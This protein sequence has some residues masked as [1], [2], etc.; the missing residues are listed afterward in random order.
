MLGSQGIEAQ[1]KG[2]D[3]L[4]VAGSCTSEAHIFFACPLELN[5]KK[6]LWLLQNMPMA[7]MSATRLHQLYMDVEQEIS[8]CFCTP[9]PGFS[10]LSLKRRL[11]DSEPNI[12]LEVRSECPAGNLKT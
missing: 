9:Y 8:S 6:R 3:L 12:S 5:L 7:Q 10:G 1:S 4:P 11:T 2:V